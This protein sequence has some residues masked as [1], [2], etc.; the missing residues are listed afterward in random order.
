M[1]RPIKKGL[2][3]F[4]FDVDFF[5]DDKIKL[6]ES[7][8]GFKGSQIAI[9]LLC[10][11]YKENGYY[12]QWGND[13]CLL[14][15][16]N[17]GAEFVPNLVNEVIMRLVKRSFFNERVFNSFQILTSKG[18]QERYIS[19]VKASKIKREKI[20]KNYA[21]IDDSE[22][23]PKTSEETGKSSEEIRKTSEEIRKTS[24]ESTQRKEKESKVNKL[25][26][27]EFIEVWKNA[28]LHY[29]KKKCGFDKLLPF[30]RQN[31]NNLL[32]DFSKE[33]FK[34][35]V[36]GLFFQDTV[37]AVRVRPDWIL[38]R[39]HFEKMLDCWV[40]KNKLFEKPKASFDAGEKFQKGDV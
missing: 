38:K 22:E 31:F 12:Y 35:A 29:D 24:E 3:Y 25:K 39:E 5:E 27:N 13:E 8:F 18:I 7:E 33:D 40:N 10:K 19:I 6:I 4:P 37:P 30:E 1:S 16:K 11:I 15:C 28:R 21:L 26:E 2:S 20:N 34:Y 14:F 32:T 23:K 17:A 36:A 9:K